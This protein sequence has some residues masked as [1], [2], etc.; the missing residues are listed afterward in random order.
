MFRASREAIMGSEPLSRLALI[1]SGITPCESDAN[2]AFV[3][4]R[5]P[6]HFDRLL[7]FTRHARCVVPAAH[8]ERDELWDEA[9]YY[10]MHVLQT[11]LRQHYA[12]ST[13]C[14]PPP[15]PPVGEDQDLVDDAAKFLMTL[16]QKSQVPPSSFLSRRFEPLP[17]TSEMTVEFR[18]NDGVLRVDVPGSKWRYEVDTNNS[19]EESQMLCTLTRKW[20][21]VTRALKNVHGDAVSIERLVSSADDSSL[22][23]NFRFSL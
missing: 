18:K 17:P 13:D 8:I 21:E 6:K 15:P 11:W 20:D 7:A 19:Y 9:V 23:L 16:L 1:V 5:N 3:I 12:R 22:S 14:H 4:S 2:N 10:H